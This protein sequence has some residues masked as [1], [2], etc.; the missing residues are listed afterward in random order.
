MKQIKKLNAILLGTI[1]CF[2]FFGCDGAVIE[3][4]TEKDS[5]MINLVETEEGDAAE[6]TAETEPEA[7][8]ESETIQETPPQYILNTS[9]LKFHY[10][11]CH[12]VKMIAKKIMRNT[13]E[14][15]RN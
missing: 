15:E 4:A 8:S 13:E 5:E 10:E 6:T 11:S 1:I 3:T 9:T 12:T 7:A 2:L 14:Q